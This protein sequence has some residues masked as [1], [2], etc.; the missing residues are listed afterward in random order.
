[1]FDRRWAALAVL[2]LVSLTG[3]LFA[4]GSTPVERSLSPQS[5]VRHSRQG[6]EVGGARLGWLR[7]ACRTAAWFLDSVG[8]LFDCSASAAV[9]FTPLS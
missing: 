2:L 9:Q 6:C 4:Q 7:T 3:R 5:S 8:F 1:M